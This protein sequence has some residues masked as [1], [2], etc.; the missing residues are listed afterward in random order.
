E[1]QTLTEPGLLYTALAEGDVDVYP[2]AWPEISQAVYMERYGDDLEDLG[3]YYDAAKGTLAVPSY[4]DIDTM[5]ELKAQADR[6]DNTIYTIEPGSGTA[7]M[8]KE[9]L[10]PAYDLSDEFTLKSSSLAAMLTLLQDSVEAKE[11]IVVTL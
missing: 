9:S 7:T 4:V 1:M 5:D 2:S 8:A 10:F 6:F 3:T 11:D